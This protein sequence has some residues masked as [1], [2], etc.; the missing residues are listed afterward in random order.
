MHGAVL[1]A[2]IV[3]SFQLVSFSEEKKL[4]VVL[5]AVRTVEI[6]FQLVSFSEEKKLLS[7]LVFF[8]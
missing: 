3:N 8:F 6:G 2:R 5:A 7:K 4:A 1:S